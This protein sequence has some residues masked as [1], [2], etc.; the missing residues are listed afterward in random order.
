VR[1]R[2][3]VLP[4]VALVCAA[5]TNERAE[6]LRTELQK[7]GEE[8][9]EIATIEKARQEADAEEAS[10]AALRADLEA[11]RADAVRAEA[12]RD[13]TRQQLDAVV[14]HD[15]RLREDIAR[16]A[17]DAQRVAERGQQLDGRL[18]VVRAR[19]TWVRDQ[20][21]V[22]A[23]EI[24]ASDESWATKRRLAALAEFTEQLAKEYPGDP[25]VVA[26]AAAAPAR[27]EHPTT[28]QIEA[29]AAQAAALRD[30]FQSVY[31]LPSPQAA[32]ATTTETSE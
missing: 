31:E 2:A 23:R 24:R 32:A 15:G 19:A 18:A 7:L 1:R 22:L 3:L 9:V 14:A 29:A 30:H 21:G 12:A 10:V 5:C 28:E 6:L 26:A 11:A 8:R 25:E 17:Q 4:L 16:V 20:A 13:A 27:A